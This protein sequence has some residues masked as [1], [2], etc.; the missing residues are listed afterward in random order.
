MRDLQTSPRS[1]WQANFGL[2]AHFPQTMDRLFKDYFQDVLPETG[3]N[4][5]E[6]IVPRLDV[7][8][9]EKGY[10]IAVEIPGVSEKDCDVTVANG[11]LTIKGKKSAESRETDEKKNVIRAERSYGSFYRSMALPDDADEA[12]IAANHKDGVLRITVPKSADGAGKSRKIEI[13]KD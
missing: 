9:N 12:K 6:L 7:S 2:P 10:E 8:E 1:W 13:R 3:K 4:G 11:M 5:G